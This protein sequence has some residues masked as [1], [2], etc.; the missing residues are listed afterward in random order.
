M[1]VSD[2]SQMTDD[3]LLIEHLNAYV[4][5][6]MLKAHGESSRQEAVRAE[7]LLRLAAARQPGVTL[8]QVVDA[9]HQAH[10][11]CLNDKL[12]DCF[13]DYGQLVEQALR[14]LPWTTTPGEYT[15]GQ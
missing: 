6:L 7:L 1:S 14:A 5:A 2:V 15:D 10:E 13:H 11:D 4:D 9:V 8:E 12:C 3:E